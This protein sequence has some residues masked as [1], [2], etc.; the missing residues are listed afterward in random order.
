MFLWCCRVNEGKP[1]P[2]LGINLSHNKIETIPRAAFE[3][4]VH[5]KKID[6]SFNNLNIQDHSTMTALT[7]LAS[8]R[9]LN[10]SGNGLI[11]LPKQFL[12]DL[13]QLSLESN[14]LEYVP[15]AL[16]HMTN[17]EELSLNKT[18]LRT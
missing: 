17:L 2:L 6:L 12:P 16:E 3:H 9:I 7:S 8:L 15:Y 11:E 4:L 10:L 13:T 18:P 14:K 5:L 1:S